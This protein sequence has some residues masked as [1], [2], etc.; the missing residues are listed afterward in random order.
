MTDR[1]PEPDEDD[2]ALSWAGDESPQRAPLR[3]AAVSDDVTPGA[4]TASPDP[5]L[6]EEPAQDAVAAPART[7]SALVFA[8]GMVGGVY[9]LFTIGWFITARSA[10]ALTDL[11]GVMYTFGQWLA[12]AAPAA[13]YGGSWLLTR[14]RPAALRLLWLVIGTLLLVPWPFIL[15]R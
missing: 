3:K 5:D 8:Y 14:H 12:V 15:S 10:S 2:D 11:G 7:S 13:W 6:V 1:A 9:V 4:A